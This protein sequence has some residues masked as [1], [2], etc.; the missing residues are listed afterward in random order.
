MRN[1]LKFYLKMLPVACTPRKNIYRKNSFILRWKV[2][3]VLS[4]FNSWFF[5]WLLLKPK[6]Y[7]H[8][9]EYH[10]TLIDVSGSFKAKPIFF[11]QKR[12]I[13]LQPYYSQKCLPSILTP[14]FSDALLK[15]MKEDCVC[16]TFSVI[17]AF[18]TPETVAHHALLSMEFSRQKYIGVGSHTLL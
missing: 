10:G 11:Y 3:R 16:I 9:P 6:G 2:T 1:F 8:Q 15:S 5:K 14:R 13:G 4:S 12:K 7:Y 18:V 17:F